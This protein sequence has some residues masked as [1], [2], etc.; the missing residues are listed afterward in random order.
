[1]KD[2]STLF[3]FSLLLILLNSCHLDELQ[4]DKLSKQVDTQPTFIAPIAKGNVTVWDLVS[5]ANNES[6]NNIVTDPNGLVKIIYTKENL[7]TY[8]ISELLD[9]PSQNN[10]T[11]GDQPVGAIS[12]QDVVISHEVNLLE[13]SE[14]VNG[15][16][17]GILLSDGNTAPFPEVLSP[18]MGA[19]FPLTDITGFKTVTLSNGTLKVEVKNNLKVPVSISGSLY[20]VTN[21]RQVAPFSFTNIAPQATS[22]LSY[23]MAGKDLSN[24]LEFRMN[25]FET[26]GSTTPVSINLRDYFS[27]T[28]S[29]TD[30]GIS[31]GMVKIEN[32]RT[33]EGSK[34]NFEFDF[35]EPNLKAFGAVLKKGSL[36][37][38]SVNE[39]PLTGVVNLVLPEIKNMLTG[40]PVTATIPLDGS[41]ISIP[42][43]NTL[44]NFASD[45]LKPYNRIP[46]RYTLTINQSNGYIDYSADDALRLDVTLDRM[47]FQ[48]VSGD[49]GKRTLQIDPGQFDLDVEILDKLKGD[50]KLDNPTLTHTVRNSVGIPAIATVN[51]MASNSQGKIVFLNPPA[52]VIPVPVGING[53]LVTRDVVINKA[54]SN[55][56]PFISLPP[57][58]QISY[59]GQIDFNP[60]DVVTPQNPNVLS[61]NA[62]FGVDMS[63]QMPLELQVSNLILKDTSAISGKD[64]KNVETADLILNVKNGVPLDIDL[65]L[66]FVDTL[67][68]QQLGATNTT[69]ML[70]AA[71]VSTDGTLAPVESSHTFSLDKTQM[72]QLKKANAIVFS[73]SLSSPN[74]G[75]TV[76]P[77]NSNS[78]I[79]MNIVVKSKVNLNF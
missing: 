4:F 20:D 64:Y 29:L 55:I 44:I 62:A 2:L 24:K 26:P 65:Q 15:K 17:D 16:L 63:L 3:L 14:K 13:L 12:P 25:S 41:T 73:G 58:G 57:T 74:N 76:A 78:R 5:A 1:M 18:N 43:D 35:P 31:K 27:L 37:I 68:G 7:F 30:L 69:R 66:L 46:Y 23:P 19:Q 53:P 8:Q 40:A 67:S 32:T 10:F 52:I 70:S 39:A 22:S 51:L 9:F 34:G 42:L 75:A 60:S 79:E 48:G 61:M 54:N 38:K 77:I 56:V 33:M 72:E 36:I 6:E 71:Q 59:S 49:F 21:N 47:E 11:S 45:P 50:F 28:F